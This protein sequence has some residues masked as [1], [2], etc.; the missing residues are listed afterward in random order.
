MAPFALGSLCMQA[1]FWARKSSGM[2]TQQQYSADIEDMLDRVV[3]IID[4]NTIDGCR[5]IQGKLK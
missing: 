4:M 2:N 3:Q 1:I 5:M